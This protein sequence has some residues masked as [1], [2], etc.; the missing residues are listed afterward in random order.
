MRECGVLRNYRKSSWCYKH[1]L[2]FLA[3]LIMKFGRVIYSADIPYTCTIGKGVVFAHNG[4]GVVVHDNAIIGDNCKIQQG[5]TIGGR[6]NRGFPKIESGVEIGA[7]ALVLGGIT[8]GENAVIGAGAIIIKDV[9]PGATMVG[10][11]AREV[12]RKQEQG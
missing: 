3:K 6:N 12:I 7:N 5:V 9:P 10:V 1:K 8:L 4:L 11:L 2:K